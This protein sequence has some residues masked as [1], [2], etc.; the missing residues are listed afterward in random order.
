[1]S[2]VRNIVEWEKLL[3][4]AED[5]ISSSQYDAG[6]YYDD[7]LSVDGLQIV[8]K[9]G[10]IAFYWFQKSCD[11]GNLQAKVRVADFLSAGTHC[12]LDVSKAILLYE[13]AIAQGSAGAAFNLGVTHREAGRFGKA[14]ECY[15]LSEV[16]SKTDGS[17]PMAL[18]Y[19]YA[20]G[21]EKNIHRCV[22]I[23]KN[24]SDHVVTSCE[25]DVDEANYFLGKLHLEG[26]GV[27]KSMELARHYLNLANT[28]ND[29]RSAKELLFVIGK[30]AAGGD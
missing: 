25:Y 7:G 24:I 26:N 6:C 9:N 10:A 13:A 20:V 5:G 1:M 8:E 21:T 17:L 16:M 15:A 4:L 11:G 29:H 27:V 2:E 14:F 30:P 19:L 3:Q 22:E 23:L 12:E 28:D 18:C